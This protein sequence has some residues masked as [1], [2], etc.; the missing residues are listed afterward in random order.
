MKI[1]FQVV[2]A[3]KSGTTSLD[4]YVRSNDQFEMEKDQRSSFFIMK[5]TSLI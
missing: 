2:G 5:A 4:V 1:I 3:Q